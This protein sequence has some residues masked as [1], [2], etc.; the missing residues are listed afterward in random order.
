MTREKHI[1]IKLLLCILKWI[2]FKYIVLKACLNHE[3]NYVFTIYLRNE[4]T[5]CIL[6]YM[7]I[8]K[9]N[10]CLISLSKHMIIH[11]L[12]LWIHDLIE[13]HK[14]LSSKSLKH[15]YDFV[16]F[17]SSEARASWEEFGLKTAR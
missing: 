7:C 9:H 17:M 16:R 4:D 13:Q 10:V 8:K 12:S 5:M 6:T 14:I 11:D 2:F 1:F 3:E 15:D